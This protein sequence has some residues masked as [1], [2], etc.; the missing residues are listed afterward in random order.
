MKK[1]FL[2]TNFLIDLMLRDEYK[3]ICKRVL[4]IGFQ[5]HMWFYI[6]FLSVANYAYIARKRPQ[7]EL[8]EDIRLI[9]ESFIVFAQNKEQIEKAISLRPK[10][11]EDALQFQCA[12][13]AGCECIITRNKKD[14]SFSDI[15]VFTAEEFLAEINL[16]S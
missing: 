15:P 5:Y 11:F 14:F 12:K 16:N 3:S 4:D 9:I 1:I 2:D 8:H 7:E 6:S 10:D 13:Q